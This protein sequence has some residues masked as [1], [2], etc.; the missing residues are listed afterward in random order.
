M[1]LQIRVK[2]FPFR[3]LP[4]MCAAYAFEP[5]SADN[6]F[7]GTG[8]EHFTVLAEGQGRNRPVMATNWIE[9]PAEW[10]TD[11]LPGGGTPEL[12]RAVIA[13]PDRNHLAIGAE[14]YAP[15]PVSLPLGGIQ[16]AQL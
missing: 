11:G 6:D 4:D 8:G 9:W 15:N 10:P 2:G 12:G 1:E 16:L 3:H 7:N 14:G 5:A 13:T